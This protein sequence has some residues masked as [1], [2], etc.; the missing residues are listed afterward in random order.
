[1]FAQQWSSR[2]RERE[3]ED[4]LGTSGFGAHRNVS[5]AVISTP[6]HHRT[7]TLMYDLIRNDT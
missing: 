2:K 5:T 6:S 3:D 7:S 4:S 1:M